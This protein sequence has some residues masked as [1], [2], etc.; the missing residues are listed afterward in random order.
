MLGVEVYER[1]WI[2]HVIPNSAE[3][4]CVNATHQALSQ[5]IEAVCHV[6][7]EWSPNVGQAEFS[8]VSSIVVIEGVPQGL[9][10]QILSRRQYAVHKLLGKGCTYQT[11]QLMEPLCHYRVTPTVLLVDLDMI[12]WRQS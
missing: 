1:R 4:T 8:K 11:M 10:E 5:K 6:P 7:V 2:A 3:D 12:L 9:A